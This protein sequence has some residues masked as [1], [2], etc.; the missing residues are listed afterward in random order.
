MADLGFAFDAAAIFEFG[1]EA[2][3]GI[4]GWHNRALYR[5]HATAGGDRR[6]QA[7]GDGGEGREKQVAE[8]VALQAGAGA[9]AVLEQPCEQRFFRG[10]GR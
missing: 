10:Q 5:Q 7:A 1:P 4:G 3:I 8:A 6:F 2:H 9:E